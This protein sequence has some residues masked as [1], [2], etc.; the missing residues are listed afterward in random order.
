MNRYFSDS[1]ICN[2][3][4]YFFI[5]ITTFTKFSLASYHPSIQRNY[6]TQ[7]IKI[8]LNFNQKQ[9]SISGKATITVV[10]LINNLSALE[11]HAKDMEIRDI[12]L[13]D[14]NALVFIADSETVAIALPHSCSLKDTITV[15]I[16]Y[17]ATPS[18]G[19]YFN[20]PTEEKPETPYQIYSHSE[21]IN[22]RR[23]FPCYDEPDDKLTS[24]IIATVPESFYLLSNG[25]LLSV[26]HN[27][28]RHAK[29]FHWLQ[30]KPHSTYLIS[31]VAG[32]YSEILDNSS[33]I[34][35]GYY[36]YK[37]QLEIAPNSFAKTPE[38]LK[39]FKESFG[40]QYP[41]DKYAQIVIADYQAAGME[42][43][44]ATTLH[45][46][47]IHDD[48][49]HLDVTSDDLISHELAHQWFGNLVTAKNWSHIWLNEGFATYAEIL[50][51]E[52][53]LG[54]AEAQYAIYQD[55][56]FYLEMVDPK[57]HQPIVYENFIH[58]DEM[59]SYIEYQKA[60]LVLHTLR[61]VIGD[62]LFFAS[63]KT[64]LKRFAYQSV[65][66]SDFQQVL[67]EV[68]GQQ[69]GWF[70]YQ[71]LYQG[72]HPEFLISSKWVPEDRE[73]YLYVRQ[74]QQDSLSLVPEVFQMTVD[75]ELIGDSD[76]LN[77]KILLTA[78]EDTFKFSFNNQPKLIRFD[79]N[80]WIL[81]E[82][83]FIKSQDEWI[84][85]LLH[86]E[87]V[88]ARLEAL[89]QLEQ[90]TF[91]TLETVLALEKCLSDDSFWAVRK[92]AA[93][94]LIDYHRPESKQVLVKAC[95]DPHPKVRT[96][97]ILSLSYYYDKKLNSLF[98]KI[99]DHDSS[100]NVV[101]EATYALSNAI[102]DSTFD[103]VSKFIDVDSHN[104]V[105]RTAA[106][107]SLRHLKDER[108]IPIAIRFA[109]DRSQPEYIRA[110]ALSILKE[111][112][113]GHQEV[114]SLMIKLLSDSSNFVK[115][116]AID[117][118]GLFKTVNSLNALKKLQDEVLPEDVRRRLKISIE[119]IE[120]GLG[121]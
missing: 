39:F 59:F 66:T 29:T 97:A 48:R 56:K 21:P 85:Q 7:H 49:A 105:I 51:K 28:K 71:W 43:T 89:E 15:V 11:F 16:S 114:E 27:R 93:Y 14:Q 68:S 80:N 12:T 45:D 118:L 3:I 35:L 6:D 99:A 31:I 110:N 104:D 92:E 88:A 67:E 34:P 63:L 100:Y 19:I 108:A 33:N 4:I 22:A 38:M 96:A 79:K 70:F 83:N 90:V 91:D 69:L 40:Y 13:A 78:R 10:P 95:S 5:I 72:G 26:H 87:H 20:E 65:V 107:H 36:V 73:V 86:D 47:T 77:E 55:Q 115:K 109:R 41:W 57:F 116:K 82:V 30:D 120:R 98:R 17:F 64:Y 58:P 32:E 76:W 25:K 8:A 42:H 111:I 54:I 121:N 1:K 62:S 9:K 46:R 101:A 60:G 53:D 23:W 24:E 117:I 74:T 75:V 52:F 106:M 94:L 102:D 37:D 61:Y 84:Y 81:K 119:K 44:S 18:A 2:W 103:F 50:F 112:G 113:S